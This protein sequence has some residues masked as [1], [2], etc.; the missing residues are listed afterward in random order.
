MLPVICYKTNSDNMDMQNKI[1]E[2][3]I[4]TSASSADYNTETIS[5]QV[6]HTDTQ[7]PSQTIEIDLE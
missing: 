4:K 5:V 1:I 7:S 2:K 6:I 3:V